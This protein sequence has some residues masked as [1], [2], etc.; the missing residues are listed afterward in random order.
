M[1]IVDVGLVEKL[2]VK[3]TDVGFYAA[4]NNIF[5]EI[6]YQTDKQ[7]TEMKLEK[8]IIKINTDLYQNEKEKSL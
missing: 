3:L 5:F 4:K 7:T 8:K 2:K 6:Y 1:Q